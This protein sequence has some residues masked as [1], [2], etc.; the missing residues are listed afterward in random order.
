M[1]SAAAH[2]TS[3]FYLCFA[4][5]AEKLTSPELR[6]LEP[7]LADEGTIQIVREA[8]GRRSPR[9][10]DKGRPG[11]S[12]DRLLRCCV[13][14]HIKGWSLRETQ[15]EIRANLVYRNFTHYYDG[16]VPDFSTLSRNFALLGDVQLRRIHDRVM[17]HARDAKLA[18]GGKLRV[19]TTVVE[20]NIHHPTDSSLL[21][22]GIRV[23]TRGLRRV[24]ELV[25][26]GSVEVVD[27]TR[28][29]SHRL[30]E[31]Q[32]AAKSKAADKAERMQGAYRKLLSVARSA[33]QQACDVGEQLWDGTLDVVGSPV[34]VLVA[35]A[36]LEHYVP[37]VSRVARQTQA[38]IFEGCLHF[39][40]KLVSLFEPHTAV[41]C[42][43]KKHK[44]VE[45]GRLVRLDEVEN[46][47]VSDWAV[48]EG[49]AS[50]QGQWEPALK[51][52][53]ERFGK[54]PRMAT[55][56]RGMQSAANEDAAAKAGVKRVVLPA[57]GRLTEERRAL[58]SQRWFRQG[59]RWRAGIEPTIARLKHCCGMARAM[60]KQA[61]GFT[62]HVGWCI[63]ANN[64][65]AVAR[66]KTGKSRRE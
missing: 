10:R 47:L 25:L 49:A 63:I 8:L 59:M 5:E 61:A 3:F 56:D 43:G 37:L 17:D 1:I 2:Q 48:A 54:A 4:E 6:A 66:R 15:E 16:S 24:A 60:Y 23:L 52:H 29:V 22:D 30:L 11:M 44:P 36:Q 19:D 13:L 18:R 26:P 65:M 41:I 45:F 31:I 40:D 28:M 38:R 42:K 9:S 64:L 7:L 32:R 20:A 33:V 50:D 35:A 62:R 34:K 14:K 53:Q 39:P 55:A 57:R 27:H 58:Q 12:P 51:A 21:G 46:G